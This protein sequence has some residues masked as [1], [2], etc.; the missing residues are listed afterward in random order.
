MKED[1]KYQGEPYIHTKD[2]PDG[3]F[4]A[5][6][7]W[8]QEKTDTKKAGW[9]VEIYHRYEKIHLDENIYFASAR[10]IKF[11]PFKSEK[12][13]KKK[14]IKLTMDFDM[15]LLAKLYYYMDNKEVKTWQ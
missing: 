9:N 11:G 2:C 14:A 8:F 12:E 1:P 4:I 5:S 7:L 15:S 10:V 6:K 3:T 13:A